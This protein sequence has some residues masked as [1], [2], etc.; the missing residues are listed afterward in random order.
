VANRLAAAG[1]NTTADEKTADYQVEVHA[2]HMPFRFSRC[3]AFLTWDIIMAVPSTF[4]PV[5]LIGDYDWLYEVS[6]WDSQGNLRAK[7][8]TVASERL[9]GLSIFGYLGAID[10][11]H[12]EQRD[13]AAAL[14]TSD[15]LDDITRYSG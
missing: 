15:L 14:L 12:P 1:W 5:P 3:A 4:L 11:Q 2:W 10:T 13:D 8:W 6:I 9:V 7:R